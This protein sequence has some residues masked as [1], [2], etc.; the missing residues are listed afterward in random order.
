MNVRDFKNWLKGYLTGCGVSSEEELSK[1]QLMKVIQMMELIVEEPRYYY[2][3]T[4][5]SIATVTNA[6]P[7]WLSNSANYV[8]KKLD[9][10]SEA[11]DETRK[12][13]LKRVQTILNRT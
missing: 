5:G 9:D 6:T 12:Q 7:N 1:E 3:P 13:L 10:V 8:E 4:W 11:A 2:Y